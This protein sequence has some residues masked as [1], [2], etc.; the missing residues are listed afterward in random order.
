MSRLYTEG[1]FLSISMLSRL[2]MTIG[3]VFIFP[4]LLVVYDVSSKLDSHSTTITL[5]VTVL[6]PYVLTEVERYTLMSTQGEFY[7]IIFFFMDPQINKH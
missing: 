2:P 5:S 4:T 7:F 6:R 3:V 1:P